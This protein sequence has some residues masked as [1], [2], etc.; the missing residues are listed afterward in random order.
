MDAIVLLSSSP[1]SSPSRG[2]EAACCGLV[3]CLGT[4]SCCV[5]VEI[6]S[7]CASSSVACVG[8]R[9]CCESSFSRFARDETG[10]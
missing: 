6:I 1:P 9:S 3:C 4:H 7:S 10:L 2:L 8:C 5:K